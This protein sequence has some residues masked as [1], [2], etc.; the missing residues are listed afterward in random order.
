MAGSWDP[1]DLPRLTAGVYAVTSCETTQYNCIAWA[2]TDILNWWE[3]VDGTMFGRPI[4]WPPGVPRNYSV[5]AYAAA[6][7]TVGYV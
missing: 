7:A 1:N 5:A 3:P 2:A 4:F 6:L